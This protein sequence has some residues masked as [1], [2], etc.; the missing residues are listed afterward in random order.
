M[1]VEGIICT[2]ITILK[3]LPD[4]NCAESE[5]L[6]FDTTLACLLA[7]EVASGKDQP[8]TLARDAYQDA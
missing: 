7:V 8:S 5:L 4:M 2:Q 3:C 1:P 6:T